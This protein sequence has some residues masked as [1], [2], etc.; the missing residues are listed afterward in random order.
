[1]SAFKP[2]PGQQQIMTYAGGLMGV[3]A[4][5]GSGKTAT[6][7]NLAARLVREGAVGTGS[8]LIVTYQNAAVD[9]I[10]T[11]IRSEL[12]HVNRPSGGYDVRTPFTTCPTG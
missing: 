6:I 10:K 7:A 1:M 5:P 9:A 2:R 11:R 12:G 4:V 3:S 8:V